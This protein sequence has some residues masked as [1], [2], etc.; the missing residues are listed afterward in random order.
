MAEKSPATA[1]K[2]FGLLAK[3]EGAG[4]VTQTSLTL[5]ANITYDR[6]AAIGVLLGRVKRTASWLIGDW[7]NAGETRFGEKYAQAI[8]DTGLT[9]GTLRNYAS[10][11][12]RVTPERRL[13]D[14]P[15]SMH[16]DVA[17]LTPEQQTEWLTRAR[18]EGWSRTQLREELKQAGLGQTPAHEPAFTERVPARYA[19]LEEIARLLADTA[20]PS[21]VTLPGEWIVTAEAMAQLRAWLGVDE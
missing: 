4:A 3:L 5:A 10:V 11:C 6:W 21:E 9:E 15:F 19:R 20:Q 18:D 13:S 8:E 12:G 16:A 17:A 1:P 14:L 7:L 2:G